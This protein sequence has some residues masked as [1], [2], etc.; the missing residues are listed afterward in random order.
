MKRKFNS[1][2]E[3]YFTQNPISRLLVSNFF[4]EVEKLTSEIEFRSV[5]DVGC[6]EGHLINYL[7]KERPNTNYYAIDLDENEINAAKMN[8]PF[9]EFFVGTIHRLPFESN[10]VDLVINTEVL[11]HVEDPGVAID[12]LYRV[13]SHYALISVPREPLWRILNIMRLHYWNDLGNTPGHLN[14]WN[15]RSFAGFLAGRFKILKI[16]KPIPWTLILCEKKPVQ[17]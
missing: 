14:H 7:S 12:E 17:E 1:N 11:E 16:S 8:C 10:F 13:T 6:G 15:S 3:K 2:H 4:N 5:L 9:G